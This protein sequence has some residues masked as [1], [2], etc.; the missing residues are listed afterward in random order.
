MWFRWP[1]HAD[2]Y[3]TAASARL[4]GKAMSD[5]EPLS[6]GLSTAIEALLKRHRVPHRLTVWLGS[7][8]VRYGV[9][10]AVQGKLSQQ[11]LHQLVLSELQLQEG[12]ANW[13]V[14]IAAPGP[15]GERL[16]AAVSKEIVLQ[17]EAATKQLKIK[18]SGIAPVLTRLRWNEQSLIEAKLPSI[19]FRQRKAVV[20]L[21]EADGL[22]AVEWDAGSIV[23]V[24]Q[25]MAGM[26]VE[27]VRQ[28]LERLQIQCGV[29][30]EEMQWVD[31]TAAA[32]IDMQQ[33]GMRAESAVTAPPF[34][35]KV[36]A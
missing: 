21:R 1:A 32:V 24:R 30:M 29:A 18:V 16:W 19:D 28:T 14:D 36:A 34:W 9:L 15:S 3:L 20:V 4:I 35:S 8:L 12:T 10:Q 26:E 23:G 27:S 17:I 33:L 5:E 7:T 22:T 13:Q 25:M 2:L 11:D 6:A 31:L